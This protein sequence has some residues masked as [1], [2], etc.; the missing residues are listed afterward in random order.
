MEMDAVTSTDSKT[1][2]GVSE[3]V[4]IV[5]M[6]ISERKLYENERLTD[7]DLDDIMFGES[8]IDL[9]M[10]DMLPPDVRVDHK[11]LKD[12]IRSISR[13]KRDDKIRKAVELF[14]VKTI[15]ENNTWRSKQNKRLDDALKA[16]L[17]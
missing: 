2:V 11:K 9:V 10:S 14:L 3:I 15:E 17:P 16:T 1:K 12:M 13:E 6:N 8:G 5:G 7:M 4:K